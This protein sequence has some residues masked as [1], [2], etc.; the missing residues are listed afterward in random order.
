MKLKVLPTK[1]YDPYFFLK[2]LNIMATVDAAKKTTMKV[3]VDP[4]FNNEL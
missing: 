4:E 2:I 3:Y 1:L